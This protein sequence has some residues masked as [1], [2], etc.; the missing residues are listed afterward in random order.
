[1]DPVN[2]RAVENPNGTVIPDVEHTGTGS[3][4]AA[5]SENLDPSA[6]E[7]NAW[8]QKARGRPLRVMVCGM[9]GA[10][11]STLINNFL[12]LD[13]DDGRAE[14]GMSGRA[15]TT[16]VSKYEKKT[17]SG[18]SVCLFDTPGFDDTEMSNEEIVAKMAIETEKKLDIVLYCLS[19]AGAARVQTG[20]KRA[21]KI[22][23]QAFTSSVWKKAVIV[24]TFANF[25]QEIKENEQKYKEVID[26]IKERIQQVLR[27]HAHVNDDIVKDIPIVTAGH[28][29]PR[30]NY[31]VECN[32][33]WQ[34]RLFLEALRRVE[35][36]VFPALFE[37]RLS[38]K[39]LQASLGEM[40]GG[41]AMG[42]GIGVGA[43]AVFGEILGLVGA[44]V[45]AGVGAGVRAAIGGVSGIGIGMATFQLVKIKR[46]LKIKYKIWKINHTQ[47]SQDDEDEATNILNT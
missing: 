21:F 38:W 12:Q 3:S 5:D 34:D 20:D 7:L 35:P 44:A 6:K 45:G 43:G 33:G 40:G 14:V 37:V 9:G 16:V 47:P 18:I 13:S 1:M 17:K 46:I 29:N 24:L 22:M 41:A 42:V 2:E 15:T 25:L 32:E 27:D 31:E 4:T 8:H 26:N 36:D 11:K 23:T 39:D 30:L 28:T 10:G 19:L